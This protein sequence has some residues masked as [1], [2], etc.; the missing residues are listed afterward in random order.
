MTLRLRIKASWEATDHRTSRAGWKP[1][2]LVSFHGELDGRVG[3][4]TEGQVLIN[5]DGGDQK[6]SG[7]THNQRRQSQK[8]S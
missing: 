8:P 4:L 5:A 2:H 7:L 6:R 3:I 1:T